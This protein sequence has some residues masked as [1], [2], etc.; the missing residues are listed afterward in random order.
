MSQGVIEI[1]LKYQ[2]L[3]GNYWKENPGYWSWI[4]FDCQ[5]TYFMI[6][7][8]ESTGIETNQRSIMTNQRSCSRTK[9][10]NFLG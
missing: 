3:E 7:S 8:K 6:R 10:I 1:H 2:E 5:T 9:Q 4:L